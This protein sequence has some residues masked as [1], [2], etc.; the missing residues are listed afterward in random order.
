LK[1]T[2]NPIHIVSKLAEDA[3]FDDPKFLEV[4]HHQIKYY[5]EIGFHLPWIGY[6]A[7]SE[8][9]VIGTCSFKGA[10]KNGKVEIAYF[11]FPEQEG[12]G[13]GNLMCACLVEIA[14][15]SDPHV[16]VSARTLPHHNASTSILKKN[17]FTLRDAVKDS[18]DG[19]VWEWILDSSVKL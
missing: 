9:K 13:F 19:E 15:A 10:P 2:L 14:K 11:T 18:E 4:Y 1:I 16:V 5:N 8:G 3:G 17:G 7:Y 6:I 12:K